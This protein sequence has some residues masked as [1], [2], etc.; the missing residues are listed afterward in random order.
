M[1]GN[2][3][4]L[5]FKGEDQGPSEVDNAREWE[6]FENI[7]DPEDGGDGQNH[8]ER[9]PK[10]KIYYHLSQSMLEVPIVVTDTISDEGVTIYA[11]SDD[12]EQEND[13]MDD[14]FDDD[15]DAGWEG[16]PEDFNIL[17]AGLR[18]Q[19]LSIPS[20]ARIDSA[21]I[22]VT[23]HEGKDAEDVA[24]LTIVGQAD[25]NPSTFTMDA[26]MTDRPQTEAS[27]FWEV[28]EEWELWA[29]YRT[30]D[31]SS[32]I[33]EIVDMDG[34]ASGNSMAFIFKGEDQGPSEV[35]NAREWE[36]FENIADPEDGGDGQNHP[37]R[38]PKLIVYFTPSTGIKDIIIAERDEVHV[39]PNPANEGFINVEFET[40]EPAIISVL[41]MNGQ[42][43]YSHKSINSTQVRLDIST[44]SKGMY[45][46]RTNQNAR[47]NFKGFIV[48]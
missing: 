38:V 20:G 33:Q 40:S 13:A 21:F 23:S 31:L 36:S 17:T 6:S 22:I 7:A 45:F 14:L 43:V 24:R 26:L 1:I 18:F 32:I 34:W 25:A 42:V 9:V 46:L 12:A 44:L 41:N 37:E 2:S 5:I 16:D 11:S 29:A 19:D 28:A 3:L 48:N 10:L 39:Y 4:S 15:I 30:P 35:D 27:V 47:I 8:P